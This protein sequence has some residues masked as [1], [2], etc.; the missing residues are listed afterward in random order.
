MSKCAYYDRPR[1]VFP[2]RE[3]K[4][5]GIDCEDRHGREPLTCWHCRHWSWETKPVCEHRKG[6]SIRPC[7][8]F[9]WD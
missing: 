7:E 1:N 5:K 6:K 9:E 8:H 4:V 2:C 3:C